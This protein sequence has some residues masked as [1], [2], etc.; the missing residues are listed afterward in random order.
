[1]APF[2]SRVWLWVLLRVHG[3]WSGPVT[4]HTFVL[5]LYLS[6]SIFVSFSVSLPL[7]LFLPVPSK[8]QTRWFFW[9]WAT[10]VALAPQIH[11]QT[12]SKWHNQVTFMKWYFEAIISSRHTL[13]YYLQYLV[14]PEQY[15]IICFY[16]DKAYSYKL[17]PYNKIILKNECYTLH[18]FI[19]RN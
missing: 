15:T 9:C 4:Q 10:K 7:A 1:M 6:P 2:W 16:V 17:K 3:R 8:D 5:I 14:H 12:L 19:F 11:K 13:L 18:V